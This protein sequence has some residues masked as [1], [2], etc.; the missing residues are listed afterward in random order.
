[1]LRS[2]AK[3]RRRFGYNARVA[4]TIERAGGV[5][6]I[7]PELAARKLLARGG[8][9]GAYGYDLAAGAFRKA[10]RAGV[11]ARDLLA[12]A[13]PASWMVNARAASP[14]FQRWLTP[15]F[16]ERWA[17]LLERLE[18]GPARW[19]AL[20]A[21]DRA[22]VGRALRD[23]A[24]DDQ[25]VAAASKTLA[26]LCPETVPLMDDAAIAFAIGGVPE[27]DGPDDP[28]AG[29]EWFTPMLDWFARAVLGA[30]AALA[31]LARGYPLAALEPAQVLDRL[32][33]F[34]S[35]GHRLFEQAGVAW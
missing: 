20:G 1:M 23:L 28:R 9:P 13:L 17:D 35:F 24:I 19:L 21:A 27:P 32:L 2:P 18:G 25:G 6:R 10:R 22:A 30:E 31:D 4:I 29:P 5:W 14:T 11:P 16:P 34:D 12:P 26:L 8:L 3:P 7:E 15:P 33:W